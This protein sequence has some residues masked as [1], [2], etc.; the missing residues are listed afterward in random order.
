MLLK[1][2]RGPYSHVFFQQVREVFQTEYMMIIVVQIQV[3]R[4]EHIID[5][6]KK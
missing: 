4:F 5:A 3:G 1:C 6:T 2:F